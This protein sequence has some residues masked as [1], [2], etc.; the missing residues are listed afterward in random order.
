MEINP[1]QLK[2]SII[3]DTASEEL[4]VENSDHGGEKELRRRKPTT[5]IY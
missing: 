2:N 1:W 5:T 4:K 3:L